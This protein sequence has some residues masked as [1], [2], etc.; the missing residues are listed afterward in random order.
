MLYLLQD[1][2]GPTFIVLVESEKRLTQAD[3]AEAKARYTECRA[4]AYRELM[5]SLDA[6]Y[7]TRPMQGWSAERLQA[8][9]AGLAHLPAMDV[10]I[11]EALGATIVPLTEI[12]TD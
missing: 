1:G 11:A 2:S 9:E 3:L 12:W 10:F 8:Y 7:P 4:A 5:R 6:A